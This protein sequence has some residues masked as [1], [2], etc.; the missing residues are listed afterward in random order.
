MALIKGEMTSEDGKIVYATVEHHKV[1]VPARPEHLA[2]RIP[3]DDEMEEREME[4]EHRK[5]R[6]PLA[7][8]AKL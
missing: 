6:K 2:A 7:N 4:T 3:W 8:A 5:Q 1:N